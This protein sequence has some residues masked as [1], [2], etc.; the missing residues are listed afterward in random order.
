MA[1]KKKPEIVKRTGLY[2]GQ[3]LEYLQTL[4]VREFAKFLPSRSRRTLLRN[5]D[6]IEN[7]LIRCEKQVVGNKKIRTHLR[8]VVIVPK[9]VGMT[10]GIHNGKAFQD[11]VMLPEMV[12]HRL[13]EF[14]MTRT[15][16]MHGTAGI[17]ATKGSKALKK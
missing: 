4:D 9:L 12:G 6:M 11:V 10:I 17:G 3:T 16:V 1:K 2:R 8:D 14:A 13:G 5:F 15:K 7:F